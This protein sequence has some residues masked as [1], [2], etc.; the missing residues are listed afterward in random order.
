MANRILVEYARNGLR[1]GVSIGRLKE[2]MLKKGYPAREIDEAIN[3]AY[4]E[5]KGKRFPFTKQKV[6]T[7]SFLIILILL[8]AIASM[9]IINKRIKVVEVPLPFEKIIAADA[10]NLRYHLLNQDIGWVATVISCEAGMADDASKCNMINNSVSRQWCV[11]YYNDYKTISGFLEKYTNVDC[12]NFK[13]KTELDG[14]FDEEV[15]LKIKQRSCAG[16]EGKREALCIALLENPERCT[17]IAENCEKDFILERA[18]ILNNAELC[19]SSKLSISEVEKCKGIVNKNCK[20]IF[21][22]ISSDLSI[23][24]YVKKSN[25]YYKCSLVKN[26][27]LKEACLDKGMDYLAVYN[28]VKSPKGET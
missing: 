18:I 1:K 17:E 13:G 16:L 10:V 24:D 8:I 6:F 22:R 2:E 25:A 12:A 15:C 5:I 9:I 21:N 19:K 28:L 26:A 27:E 20:D 7:I 3:K 11:N 4:S 14:S 23:I